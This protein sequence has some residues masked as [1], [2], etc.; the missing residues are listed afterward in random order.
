MLPYFILGNGYVLCVFYHC[1]PPQNIY[2][3]WLEAIVEVSRL[4]PSLIF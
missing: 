2:F 3:R 4:P 1:Y